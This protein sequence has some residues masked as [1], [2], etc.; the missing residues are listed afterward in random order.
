[1]FS[2]LFADLAQPFGEFVSP[3]VFGLEPAASNAAPI[4]IEE[5]TT[6]ELALVGILTLA[7]FSIA[8]RYRRQQDE[9]TGASRKSHRAGAS[10]AARE[11][12][13][14]EAA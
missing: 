1:M 12:A 4:V 10:E 6:L 11:S 5:P 9:A 3:L 2:P 7:I 14:R 13:P 8:G